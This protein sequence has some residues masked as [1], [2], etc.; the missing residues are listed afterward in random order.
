MNTCRA[1][2][3]I[4]V[5]THSHRHIIQ[6]THKHAR[7]HTHTLKCTH[8]H[9]HTHT[10][11]HQSISLRKCGI[12]EDPSEYYLAEIINSSKG[13]ERELKPDEHPFDIPKREQDS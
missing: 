2:L 12:S 9:T 13:E 4:H 7:T 8:T 3:Y 1:P 5:H 10:H 6:H 11:S